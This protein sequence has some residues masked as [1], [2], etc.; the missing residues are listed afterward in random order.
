MMRLHTRQQN[1]T[2]GRRQ[3]GE[4][5]VRCVHKAAG[6]CTGR[7]HALHRP[8]AC[9][10]AACGPHRAFVCPLHL[11]DLY[12]GPPA[13]DFDNLPRVVDVHHCVACAGR[14][15][16][17]VVQVTCGHHSGCMAPARQTPARHPHT[18]ARPTPTGVGM[19]QALA[20]GS[21]AAAALVLQILELRIKHCTGKRGWLVGRPAQCGLQAVQGSWRGRKQGKASPL[22]RGRPEACGRTL[23]AGRA[24]VGPVALGS[25][26]H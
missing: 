1:C 21:V 12:R 19:I 22:P 6:C 2:P 24:G 11:V 9:P 14:C 25:L 13:R 4:A 8:T 15:Q 20:V 18:Q 10:R 23:A 7:P 16:R 17:R 3:A 5:A 26:P